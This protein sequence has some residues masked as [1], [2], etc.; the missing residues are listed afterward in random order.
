MSFGGQYQTLRQ[1]GGAADQTT[2][3]LLSGEPA[4]PPEPQA[5]TVPNHDYHFDHNRAAL[6]RVYNVFEVMNNI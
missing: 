5:P 4:L 1:T 2:N 3:L 6:D